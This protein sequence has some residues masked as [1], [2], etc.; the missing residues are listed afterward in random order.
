MVDSNKATSKKPGSFRLIVTTQYLQSLVAKMWVY[1]HAAELASC[2]IFKK[3][4]IFGLTSCCDQE[5]VAVGC[6]LSED[7]NN[8]VSAFMIAAKALTHFEVVVFG[9][10]RRSCHT[11]IVNI[12]ERYLRPVITLIRSGR[13]DR[14]NK[15]YGR[16]YYVRLD[17]APSRNLHFKSY[18]YCSSTGTYTLW[19]CVMVAKKSTVKKML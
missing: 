11:P 4:T 14:N 19:C 18:R 3:L 10:L 7:H 6:T 9:S 16:F 13:Q 1:H 12:M 5:Q 8:S 15:C 2:V 17:L